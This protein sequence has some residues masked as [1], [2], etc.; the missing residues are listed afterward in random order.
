MYRLI[1]LVFIFLSVSSFAMNSEEWALAQEL[2]PE[3]FPGSKGPMLGSGKQVSKEPTSFQPNMGQMPS[4]VDFM[5][6][7]KGYRMYVAGTD[8][9]FDMLSQDEG[10]PG[11]APGV[12]TVNLVGA[13]MMLAG[14]GEDKR[15]GISNYLYG[16]DQSKWVYNV[17]TYSKVR[18]SEIY[19]GIDLV[20]YGNSERSME[21]DF[22]VSPG[23]D[24]HDIKLEIQGASQIEISKQGH[25]NIEAI[26]GGKLRLKKPLVYQTTSMGVKIE[27]PSHYELNADNQVS[28]WIDESQYDRS[29][30]LII[31]PVTLSYSSY[32]GGSSDDVVTTM[33]VDTS[34][35]IYVGGWTQSNAFPTSGAGVDASLA[36]TTDGF[37]SKISSTGTLSISTYFGGS[38]L[39]VVTSLKL[40][41]SA[42]ACNIYVAGYTTSTDFPRTYTNTPASP[43]WA[44]YQGNYDGFAARFS[45][46][47]T[48][49]LNDC[50]N[51]QLCFST[52]FGAAGFDAIMGIDLDQ[53][54]SGCTTSGQPCVIAVGTTSST[55]ALSASNSPFGGADAFVAKLLTSDPFSSNVLRYYG[56]AGTDAGIAVAVEKSGTTPSYYFAGFTDSDNTASNIA[57]SGVVGTSNSGLKDGFVVKY[58]TGINS[59]T[60]GTFIGGTGTERIG[61]LALNPTD[62]SSVAY[63]VGTTTSSSI[64]SATGTNSSG[65]PSAGN[66][67]IFLAKLNSGATG[68]TYLTF[69][70]GSANDEVL[71]VQSLA[72]DSNGLAWF[73]GQ[74]ASSGLSTTGTA[75][76]TNYTTYPG[77]SAKVGLFGRVSS[78]SSATTYSFLSYL[79][80]GSSSAI[81]LLSSVT[82]ASGNNTTAY[83][84]GY[85]S[86]S[87]VTTYGTTVRAYTTSGLK[88]NITNNFFTNECPSSLSDCIRAYSAAGLEVLV[89]KPSSASSSGTTPTQT[90]S[91]PTPAGIS[92]NTYRVSSVGGISSDVNVFLTEMV[93]SPRTVSP[94]LL[95]PTGTTASAATSGGATATVNAYSIIIRFNGGVISG[96]S[97]N[98]GTEGDYTIC[99][100]TA[101]SSGNDST[102]SATVPSGYT[103]IGGGAWDDMTLNGSR[104]HHLYASYPSNTLSNGTWTVSGKDNP[105]L[106]PR[107][108]ASVTAYAIGLK[109]SF[110]TANSLT[111][112]VS[113]T[114]VGPT[115][116]GF[117]TGQTATVSSGVLIGGG[118]K[119]NQGGGN[120]Q[121]LYQSYPSSQ[122]QWTA[123][124]F[125]AWSLDTT[126]SLTIY[127]IGISSP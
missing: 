123:S 80:S 79:S 70:G 98:C 15:P 38:G 78:A 31:D 72:V 26:G 16:S 19:R 84:G 100:G 77:G 57:S 125:G 127:A 37:L 55:S 9:V 22:I 10:H 62:S 3:G 75:S 43:F 112:S 8:L 20:F 28:F 85:A 106:S 115:T 13:N 53:T 91:L 69:I 108:S 23:A 87:G 119:V 117:F 35:N 97:T 114:T 61:G 4:D 58:N 74:T 24:Y 44:S 121:W 83:L 86:E 95:N 25:I 120:G 5:A 45:Q 52:Y 54:S 59:R 34:G 88:D 41:S 18:Y 33:T 60:W 40:E 110:L 64:N 73:A 42:G 66:K 30:D 39:E 122:T 65:N 102:A 14:H 7:S 46:N 71:G 51:S 126:P 47:L 94:T 49:G 36:G 99:V 92:P 124:S 11:V 56:N 82:L 104:G 2:L 32:L 90:I 93:P 29:L 96:P 107:I 111:A 101:S 113:S 27:I 63:V 48:V 68:Y 105:A 21:H 67:D 1:C 12:V 89:M 17:P 76:G 81:D 6:K 109:T 118:A 116:D 50:N 103:L